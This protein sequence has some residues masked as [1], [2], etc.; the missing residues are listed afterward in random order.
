[1]PGTLNVNVVSPDRQV[2][3]GEATGVRAPGVEGSFEVRHNHA[4]MIAA[5]GVGEI[6]ITNLAGEAI[7]YA[8]SGG[9]LEVIENQVTVLAETAEPAAE[10]DVERARAAEERALER[11]RNAEDLEERARVEQ[12]LQRARNRLRLGMG[13]VGTA[14]ITARR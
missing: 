1:M 10:I 12:A 3:S 13:Q 2:F 5:F 14:R 6:H 11:L 9:F 7:V 4:P 8:T